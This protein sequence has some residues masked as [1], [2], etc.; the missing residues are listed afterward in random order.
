MQP[1]S[2]ILKHRSL[3]AQQQCGQIWNEFV[4]LPKM[5]ITRGLQVNIR[6]PLAR[7]WHIRAI[8]PHTNPRISHYAVCQHVPPRSRPRF[9]KESR[10]SCHITFLHRGKVLIPAAEDFVRRDENATG[11][12]LQIQG[13]GSLKLHNGARPGECTVSP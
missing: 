10:V 1:V 9:L 8:D 6:K 3:G 11:H 12:R 13:F 5:R 4:L 7:L 2:E